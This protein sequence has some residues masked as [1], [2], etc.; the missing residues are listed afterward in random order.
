MTTK[1]PIPIAQL[2]RIDKK[3]HYDCSELAKKKIDMNLKLKKSNI[4]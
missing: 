2:K 1:M 3:E 4:A